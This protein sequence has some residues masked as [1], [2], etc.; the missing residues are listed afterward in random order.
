ML[1]YH[2]DNKCKNQYFIYNIYVFPEIIDTY[3]SA[4]VNVT[5]NW[6]LPVGQKALCWS[7]WQYIQ[8]Q[9]FL[10]YTTWILALLHEDTVCLVSLVKD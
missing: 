5:V 3:G 8:F 7:I 1:I 9:L 2:D 10:K 4:T 6:A